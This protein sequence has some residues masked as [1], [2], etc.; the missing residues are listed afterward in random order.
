MRY[1]EIYRTRVFLYKTYIIDLFIC[2][3][4]NAEK[5][6]IRDIKVS[7]KNNIITSIFFIICQF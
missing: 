4:K 5:K 6:K 2:A 7:K 3:L 1:I